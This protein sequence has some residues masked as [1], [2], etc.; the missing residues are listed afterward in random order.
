MMSKDYAVLIW[1]FFRTIT[2]VDV[3]HLPH[4]SCRCKFGSKQTVSAILVFWIMQYYAVVL[5]T[6]VMLV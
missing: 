2:G 3:S 1:I 4:S 5:V 6:T